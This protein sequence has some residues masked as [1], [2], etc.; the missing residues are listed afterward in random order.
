MRSTKRVTGAIFAALAMLAATFGSASP[1]AAHD[2]ENDGHIPAN[3]NYGFEVVGRDTLEGL[4]DGKYTDVWSLNGFAYIGTFQEPECTTAGVFVVDI[5]QAIANYPDISGATVAEIPSPVGI[6]VNDVKA[7][8]I[9]DQDIL[10]TTEE[11]CTNFTG[12]TSEEPP[13]NA[14]CLDC[15]FTSSDR[16]GVEDSGERIDINEDQDS[17]PGRSAESFSIWDVTDPTN[18][19]QLVESF[20]DLNGV[21]NTFPWQGVDGNTYLIGTADSFDFLDTFLIDISDPAN[22][23]PINLTYGALDWIDQGVNLDQ[24]ETGQSAGVFNHDVWVNRID[25]KD[26]AVIP[27]WDL[28]FVTVDVTDP[29]NPIFLGDS[30]YPETDPLGRPY[31]GNAHAAVFGGDGDYIF[32]GDEDF[33]PAALGITFNDEAY[34]AGTANFGPSTDDVP[35]AGDVVWTEGEG[36]TN[37][38]VPP[39][40]AEGQIALIQR[41]ACGFSVKAASASVQGYA[42]Y[43]VANVEAEGDAI[44]AMAP[45]DRVDEV[46]IPGA[47]VGYGTG[48]LMKAGGTI[49]GFGPILF[50]GWGYLRVLNNI[51]GTVQVPSQ[52]SGA[53]P[54]VDAN[55]LDEIGYYAPAETLENLFPDDPTEFGDLTMHNIEADPITQDLTPTFDFGPRM[56]V[57]WYSLGMRALEYRPGHWHTN[58]NGEG[59]YSWNVHEVGRFIA[60]DGSNFWGVHLDTAVIDGEEQ[61]IILGSDRNTGLWIFTF[62]C[63]NDIDGTSFYCQRPIEASIPEIQGEAHTSPS[64]NLLVQ[65]T[66]VVTAVD[67]DGFYLQDPTGDGNDATSDAVF[68][69]STS[70]VEVGQAL[71]VTG[72]VNEIIPGGEDTGNLSV[73]QIRETDLEVTGTSSLPDPTLIGQGGRNASGTTVISESE[74]PTNLQTDAAVYNPDTDA[75]DFWESLEGMLVKVDNPK[76][77]SGMRQFSSTSSEIF[78]LA[79]WGNIFEP[80]SARSWRGGLLLQPDLQNQGDQNPERVQIQF[81]SLYEGEVPEASITTVFNDVRGVVGYSFGNFEVNAIDPVT[82]ANG[83]YLRPDTTPLN[84]SRERVTVASYNV[85]NL[86]PGDSEQLAT[87][88]QQIADNLN[89]PDIVALQEIQDNSGE[90]DDGVTAADQTLAA[91]VAAIED[92]GG[93]SYEAVDVAPVDNS[94][95][96]VPGGN[97]RNAFLYNPERFDL[98]ELQDLN[99]DTLADYGVTDPAAFDGSRVPLLGTFEFVGESGLS[100]LGSI[101]VINNHLT[102]RFGSTPVFGAIQPFVQAGEAEREAQALALNE[103]VDARTAANADERVAVVGDLN[104]FEWTDELLEDLPGDDEVLVNMATN[105]NLDQDGGNRFSFNFE[106]N[107]QLLDHIFANQSLLE[108]PARMDIVHVNTEFPRVD[109]SFGSDHE[110]VVASFTL[111]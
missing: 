18:P 74:L 7:I 85:L 8:T 10:I 102:S 70:N 88:G 40:T 68:V 94:Q 81:G 90:T 23:I 41:G 91:L 45:S 28:G 87:L 15:G 46:T 107:Q 57:S 50:D 31:E 103:V 44:L 6:R 21:H 25:G 42:G 89:S 79:S 48:E 26:I 83:G 97:I 39:A 69:E 109:A 105:G 16:D 82:V 59:S 49:T 108:G 37:E 55:Y 30:T 63:S 32:G 54:T 80:T 64:E 100:D 58:S 24:V 96:G 75:I 99:P 98:T 110:P 61:Q 67:A 104:T 92:A 84:A 66:G 22:P 93:P 53:E 101:T 3:T 17:V 36:C 95:G 4:T 1:A 106:G 65:T 2:S 13:P 11:A 34:D 35:L 77:V 27:Y 76:A 78:T 47:F 72:I 38:E 111:R 14:P 29:A 60:D 56:F 12:P 51:D 33:D 86:S 43:V 71:T 5:D 20:R 9:G 19:T 62:D 73:T 52:A